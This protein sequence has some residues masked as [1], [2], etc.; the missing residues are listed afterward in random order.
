MENI[1]KLY[2]KEDG[3]PLYTHYNGSWNIMKMET[4]D[5]LDYSMTISEM[6]DDMVYQHEEEEGVELEGDEYIKLIAGELEYLAEVVGFELVKSSWFDNKESEFNYLHEQ[7]MN[8]SGVCDYIFKGGEKPHFTKVWEEV[9][10]S[11]SN[12]YTM[13]YIRQIVMGYNNT[14]QFSFCIQQDKKFWNK[15]EKMKSRV[16]SGDVDKLWDILSEL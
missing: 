7:M 2:I 3:T 6:L 12:P 4:T 10:E 5:G 1:T 15:V 16:E 9:S 14:E 11:K 13:E 8:T